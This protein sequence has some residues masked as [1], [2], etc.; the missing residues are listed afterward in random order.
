MCS[1]Y[2]AVFRI[3]IYS[4][5]L[6]LEDFP[7]FFYTTGRIFFFQECDLHIDVGDLSYRGVML[8]G[9]TVFGNAQD[10]YITGYFILF[11]EYLIFCTFL[12]GSR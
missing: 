6:Y 3:S 7:Q 1:F 12:N 9:S 5:F 4:W 2:K 10:M 8:L 11:F